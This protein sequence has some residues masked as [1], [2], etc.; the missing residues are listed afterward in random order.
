M[1][2]PPAMKNATPLPAR[3]HV[4]CLPTPA[5]LSAR[6][7]KQRPLSAMGGGESSASLTSCRQTVGRFSPPVMLKRFYARRVI[8]FEMLRAKPV[9]AAA[10]DPR[11]SSGAH[12]AQTQHA[13]ITRCAKERKMTKC[14]F[15]SNARV[16]PWCQS[17][18]ARHAATKHRL[19]SR[20]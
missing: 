10:R 11:R 3:A 19:R 9:K 14:C 18:R 20:G 16:L 15:C 13:T 1:S 2:T 8:E 17:A 4:A 5:A 7:A 12:H 6:S